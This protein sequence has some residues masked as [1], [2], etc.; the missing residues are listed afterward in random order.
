[1][2]NANESTLAAMKNVI[3]MRGGKATIHGILGVIDLSRMWY[4]PLYLL[5]F[6]IAFFLFY[7]LDAA[8]LYYIFPAAVSGPWYHGRH[9]YYNHI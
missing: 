4:D 9:T 2:T 6:S 5:A 7:A 1:M 8:V 3:E